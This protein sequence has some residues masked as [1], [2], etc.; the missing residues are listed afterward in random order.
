MLTFWSYFGSS[1]RQKGD[2]GKLWEALGGAW[3]EKVAIG[4]A[5]RS[6]R[7]NQMA[8]NARIEAVWG[9]KKWNFQSKNA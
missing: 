8:K 1:W 5:K 7:A 4:T 2:P 6:K 9:S 3:G